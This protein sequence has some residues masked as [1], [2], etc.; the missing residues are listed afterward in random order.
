M[1]EVQLTRRSVVLAGAAL[2]ACSVDM[3]PE[4]LSATVNDL[5][6]IFRT[7]TIQLSRAADVEVEYGPT[8]G[9]TP[10][11]VR[12]NAPNQ[13][14]HVVSLP[15]LRAGQAYSFRL[16]PDPINNQWFDHYRDFTTGALPADLAAM[17]FTP[18]GNPTM[19]LLFLSVRSQFTG[20]VILDKQGQVVWYGRTDGA[21]QGACR[22]ANGHWVLVSGYG[23]EEFDE[24]GR[25]VDRLA[26]AQVPGVRADIHHGVTESPD[27]KL[28]FIRL[29]P[30]VFG[31]ETLY[32]ES[33]W[34]WDGGSSTPVR[35]WNAWDFFDPAVDRGARSIP[36]DWLHA[37]HV[38][39][40][41]SGN[42]LLSMH[43]LDQIIS[44]APDFRS[45][46]WRL[47]GPGSSFTLAT[48]QVFSGQHS[49]REVGTNRVLFFDNGFARAD[50][51]RYSRL[52][53]FELT[54]ATGA[55]R[56]TW[57]FRPTPDIW[58][59][60]ISS[61]RRLSNGNTVGTFGTPAGVLGSTGPITMLEVTA[62]GTQ[63]AGMRIEGPGLTT[64]FQG[65]PI[66]S[67]AG[68]QPAT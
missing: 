10:L 32:G 36:T 4:V 59:T 1:N 21:P 23:L 42:V 47:G 3:A 40:G 63:V 67:V 56:T 34:R 5:G 31:T 12:T 22:R 29:E 55:V 30:Q 66:A 46:Q 58:A 62:A 50:G 53:E 68:E 16:R 26:H 14:T 13:T 25:V 45:I 9:S 8:G 7:V 6:P 60:V 64:V 38:S 51:G 19:P 48:D 33:L 20:G 43:F 41:A 11:R 49:A 24:M 18:S 57:Q 44:I 28:V 65:D 15:R 35:L 39:F 61:A 37:N 27:G 2:A 17:R 54:S 52:M